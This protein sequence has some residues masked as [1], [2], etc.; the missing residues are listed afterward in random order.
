[1]RIRAINETTSAIEAEEGKTLRRQGSMRHPPIKRLIV[2]NSR[3][4]QY[5]EVE[6]PESTGEEAS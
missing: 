5:E 3:I 1:M 6:A 4:C 2:N